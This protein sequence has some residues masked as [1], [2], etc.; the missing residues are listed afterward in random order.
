MS[1]GEDYVEGGE[2]ESGDGPGE[3]AFEAGK[4]QKDAAEDEEYPAPDSGET[5]QYIPTPPPKTP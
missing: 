3:V 5:E 2:D 1:D 4:K